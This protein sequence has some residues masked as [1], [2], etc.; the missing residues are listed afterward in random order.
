MGSYFLIRSRDRRDGSGVSQKETRWLP[1][2]IDSN[3]SMG[4]RSRDLYAKTNRKIRRI[5]GGWLG[6]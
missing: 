4:G 6:S 2:Q 1:Q 5:E 3:N